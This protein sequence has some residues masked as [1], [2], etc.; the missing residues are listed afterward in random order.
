MDLIN[1]SFRALDAEDRSLL[2]N[3]PNG[4]FFTADRPIKDQ[5]ADDDDKCQFVEPLTP[6]FIDTGNALSLPARET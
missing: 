5:P 6:R 4:T 3:C 1:P 2:C